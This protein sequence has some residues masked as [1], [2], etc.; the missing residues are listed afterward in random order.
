MKNAIVAVMR[1]VIGGMFVYLGW[2]KIQDPVAFLKTIREFGVLTEYWQM[3]AVAAWLPWFEIWCG[4]LLV[5]GIG[6]RT[7]AATVG[8]LLVA[9]TGMILW[10]AIQ[11]HGG[12]GIAFCDIKFDCGCGTGEVVVCYKLAQNCLLT[13]ASFVLTFVKEH[14]LCIWPHIRIGSVQPAS[15]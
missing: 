15:E 1:V 2:N 5:L 6:V 8:T 10:R 4:G 13:L 14:R 7:A 3:N 12:G 11:V 9:F